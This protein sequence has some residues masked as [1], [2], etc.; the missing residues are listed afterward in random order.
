MKISKTQFKDYARCEC[1]AGLDEIY[2]KKNRA[3][4]D[5]NEIN[6][7]LSKMFTEDGDDEIEVTNEQ[8][9]LLKPYYKDVERLAMREASVL[10]GKKFEYFENN[11]EQMM[12]SYYDTYGN[13]LYTYLDGF[14][15][16]DNEIII[17]EVKATTNRKFLELGPKRKEIL[18]PVFE[19]KDGV[20]KLK[21]ETR[22]D[23]KYKLALGKLKDKNHGCGKYIYD[24]AVT[25]FIMD[26]FRL[27][28]Y[29]L[30]H[31]K[32]KY[33]LA[34]LNSNYVYSGIGDYETNDESIIEFIDVTEICSDFQNIIKEEYQTIIKNLND[35][36]IKSK[37]KPLCDGCKY[38]KVC[39]PALGEKDNVRTLLS[40]KEVNEMKW[41]NLMNNN[42]MKITDIPYSWFT[43]KKHQIQYDCIVNKKEYIN[44][45]EVTKKIKEIKYP[46]YHL[47][48]E[49]LNFPLPRFFGES[50]FD[51]SLF[52]FSIHVQK[53]P[54]ICDKVKDNYN[55]LPYDFEDCREELIKKMIDIIDLSKGGTVLVFNESFEKN[56]IKELIKIFPKYEK[57]L[58][59]I[60]D[61]I[62]DLKK[63]FESEKDLMKYYHYKLNGSY[64]IKKIL[65][66]YS[67]TSYSDFEV[68]NGLDAQTSYLM[69]KTLPKEDIELERE[70]LLIYCG[71]D[72][73][74]MV[75]ILD[76]LIKKLNIK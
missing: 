47:D 40:S 27:E 21:E 74:S 68:K 57:E 17:I 23:D 76:G 54:F 28:N 75:E 60:N 58:Q 29:R 10:F 33:Y 55:F 32:V 51:H 7:I 8:F 13:Q 46:I 25:N 62:Y 52:Q 59:K 4:Q 36:P 26:G 35:K 43:N 39:C 14:N 3:N 70:K 31:K 16:D 6:G 30:Y 24:L 50:P 38:Q 45:E 34:V 20:L 1:F 22:Y 11:N 71:Q 48:F 73:Y 53:S 44:E 15:E 37:I 61:A 42:Y 66:I 65:P 56:R 2:H 49:S 5:E 64:S 41:Y 12:I 63:V 9:E 72:T 69:F 19:K 18:Y 67:A